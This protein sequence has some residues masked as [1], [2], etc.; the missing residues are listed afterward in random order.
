MCCFIIQCTSY[1]FNILSLKTPPT[2]VHVPIKGPYCKQ[3][4]IRDEIR[5]SDIEIYS[6]CLLI[7][8]FNEFNEFSGLQCKV[9]R[10]IT[11]FSNEQNI[12]STAVLYRV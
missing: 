3:T 6:N 11:I 7:L 9:L 12:E 10:V 2:Q 5:N 1:V 8:F 4:D